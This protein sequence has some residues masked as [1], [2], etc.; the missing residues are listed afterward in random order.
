M[1]T[2]C[3]FCVWMCVFVCVCVGPNCNLTWLDPLNGALEVMEY[4]SVEDTGQTTR[5]NKQACLT[6][7]AA[8]LGIMINNYIVCKSNDHSLNPAYPSRFTHILL[9]FSVLRVR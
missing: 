5:G 3:R 2:N 6:V 4:L 1:S 8:S 7:T 9:L